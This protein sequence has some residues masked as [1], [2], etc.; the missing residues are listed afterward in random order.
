MND[1]DPVLADEIYR[2]VCTRISELLVEF[3]DRLKSENP[4]A[5][6]VAQDAMNSIEEWSKGSYLMLVESVPRQVAQAGDTVLFHFDHPDLGGLPGAVEVT[7]YGKKYEEMTIAERKLREGRGARLSISYDE[8]NP[9]F[10]LSLIGAERREALSGRFDKSANSD[11]SAIHAAT[12]FDM[13]SQHA[14]KQSRQY[15][16]SKLSVMVGKNARA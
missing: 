4:K 10:A 13:F 16:A 12:S 7:K 14:P 8:A 5:W 3:D 2:G 11:P 9:N 1:I 6:K 15:L